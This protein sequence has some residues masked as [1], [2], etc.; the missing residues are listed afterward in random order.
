MTVILSPL[1]GYMANSIVIS[2]SGQ[3][4]VG[5]AHFP[6]NFHGIRRWTVPHTSVYVVVKENIHILS[7][8]LPH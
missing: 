8:S 1:I 5:S 6:A 2:G 7:L 4:D 3:P